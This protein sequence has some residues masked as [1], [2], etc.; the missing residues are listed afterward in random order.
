MGTGTRINILDEESDQLIDECS[1]QD[2]PFHT[3]AMEP[4][5]PLQKE[6]V[7]ITP[8]EGTS[9]QLATPE[10][11]PTPSRG[12]SGNPAGAATQNR[13]PIFVDMV[14]PVEV[15]LEEPHPPIVPA[16]APELDPEPIDVLTFV[17]AKVLEIVPDVQSDHVMALLHS[18]LDREEA[19]MSPALLVEQILHQLFENPDYPKVE[20]KGAKRKTAEEPAAIQNGDERP[21]KK[22]KIDYRTTQRPK[23]PSPAYKNLALVSLFI[24]EGAVSIL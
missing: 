10:T 4:L 1:H 11:P 14:Q 19:L 18:S 12:S 13:D 22:V 20:K 17:L 24:R 9:L 21:K 15:P 16:V 23:V 6:S 7:R 5:Q 2:H 8:L 3:R